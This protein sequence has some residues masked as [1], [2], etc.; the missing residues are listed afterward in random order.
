MF[1]RP[2]W[3]AGAMSPNRGPV[4]LGGAAAVA[5]EGPTPKQHSSMTLSSRGWCPGPDDGSRAETKSRLHRIMRS[6]IVAPVAVPTTPRGPLGNS[7]FVR[8]FLTA[9]PQWRYLR[10][11][12]VHF[13]RTK[14][15]PFLIWNMTDQLLPAHDPIREV[16]LY[17]PPL[18][19]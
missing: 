2:L 4:P 14:V 9:S 13:G 17:I 18:P 16:F 6:A 11:P 3:G 8:I 7:R 10:P 5:A 19:P 1:G 15:P 12:E